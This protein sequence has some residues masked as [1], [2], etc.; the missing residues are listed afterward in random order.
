MFIDHLFFHLTQ[1]MLNIFLPTYQLL[2]NS[3]NIILS[4]LAC[5]M[6]CVSPYRRLIL[7]H[8]D[9]FKKSFPFLRHLILF[10]CS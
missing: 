3:D 2:V 9:S 10:C 1:V 6:A 7:L 4:L 5:A 8:S